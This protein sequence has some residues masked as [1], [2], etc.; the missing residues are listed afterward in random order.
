MPRWPLR[1]ENKAPFPRFYVRAACILAAEEIRGAFCLFGP[2]VAVILAPFFR[3]NT[4]EY[5]LEQSTQ[6]DDTSMDHMDGGSSTARNSSVVRTPCLVL[7]NCDENCSFHLAVTTR[8]TS[9]TE[10]KDWLH[11]SLGK[12]PV[13][14][15]WRLPKLL[16]DRMSSK[17]LY[18]SSSYPP[19]KPTCRFAAQCLKGNNNVTDPAKNN[20]DSARSRIGVELQVQPRPSPCSMPIVLGSSSSHRR[21]VMEALGWQ[22]RW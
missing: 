18:Q 21:A 12:N 16:A 20:E 17:L 22:V 8:K 11:V 19:E 14:Y 10:E 1:A 15:L 13:V 5:L 9:K 6:Y 2:N 3:E 7:S 4:E